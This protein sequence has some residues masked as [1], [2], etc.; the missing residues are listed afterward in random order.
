MPPTR[1][2]FPHSRTALLIVDVINPLD[3]AGGAAFVP[4]ALRIARAIDRL[5]RRARSA[6]VPVIFVNDNFGRW[7]SDIEGLIDFVARPTNPGAA[8][9]KVLRPDGRDFV[10]LKSTL[11]GFYQTPLDAMLRMG[12]VR[13]VVVTGLVT[14]NCVLLTAADAYMRDYK[15]IVPSDCVTD[16]TETKQAAALTKLADVMKATVRPS[17]RLRFRT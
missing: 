2:R 16:Q 3:F 7:R 12:G 8:L 10:V 4:K 17:S 15:V 1:S 14:G 13:Q 9:V 11:S 5:A 6:G